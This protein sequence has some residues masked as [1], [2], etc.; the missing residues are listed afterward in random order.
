[1]E[2]K[3]NVGIANK[4][5]LAI[6]SILVLI[7]A[8]WIFAQSATDASIRYAI[9]SVLMVAGIALQ[10]YIYKKGG[11]IPKNGKRTI[12][13][14]IIFWSAMTALAVLIALII[15]VYFMIYRQA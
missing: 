14:E 9:F 13:S 15:A 2:K 10:V 5:L 1:M 4:Y 6:L 7:S 3:L 8:F 11:F 12:H